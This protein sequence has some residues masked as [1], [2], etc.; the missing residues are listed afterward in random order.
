V[1]TY[2]HYINGAFVESR[3]GRRFPTDDP[4]TGEVWAEVARG[5][6]EDMAA[7]IESA[8]AAFDSPAW[9]GLTPSARGALLRRIGDVIAANAEYLAGVE[10]RDNGKLMAEMLAQ[11][12][13]LPNYY[14]YYGG[15]ADKVEGSNIPLDKPGYLNVTEYIPLGVIGIITPWNSP[16][17]L[18]T[19]KLAPALAAGNTVVIKPSEFTSVSMLELARLIDEAGILPPGVLNVVTGFGPEVGPTMVS[20]PKVAKIAFTGS[21]ATGRAIYAD[22][23]RAMKH[24]TMELGGKS[25]NIVFEDADLDEAVAGAISGIFAATGQTCLAGSRLLVQDS[26]HDAFLER[27]VQI[28]RTATLGNP[29][30]AGTQIGP[31]TTP[32]QFAKV[33]DYIEIAKA[34]GA[35]L[36]VGGER[37]DLEICRRGRFVQP[38][39]FADVTNDMRI[40]RE[41]VFG[42]VLAVIRFRDEADAIRIANDTIY[43]LAAG[44]WTRDMGRAVRMARAIRAG[45]VWINTYRA[46]SYMSPFGGVGQSGIGRE[47]GAEM[48]KQYLQPKS[49][50]MNIGAPPAN[51]FVQR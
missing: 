9:S 18:T 32:Q 51:P 5:G 1:K 7:A 30:E 41:E 26:I 10:V 20:H 22:A 42:P 34:E 8:A 11:L 47:N 44:V 28:T 19:W 48:I 29:A 25:P 38:T 4:F 3:D 16:L 15:L 27:L 39:V 43:G 46:L 2:A 23:A 49:I 33:L 37:P 14:Y 12:R 21:D 17:N 50:W 24:V 45:T 35:R 31:V 40:A 6:A 36:V 13:Y